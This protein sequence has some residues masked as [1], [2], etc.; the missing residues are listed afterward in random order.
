VEICH[1]EDIALP[2]VKVDADDL[3]ARQVVGRTMRRLFQ[4]A[5]ASASG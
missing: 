3:A 5:S 4:A 2:H 1:Q